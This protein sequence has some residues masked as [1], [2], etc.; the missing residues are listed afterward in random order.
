MTHTNRPLVILKVSTLVASLYPKLTQIKQ[1]K[2]N[3]IY[4]KLIL[5]ANVINILKYDDHDDY[6]AHCYSLLLMAMLIVQALH[7]QATSR[8]PKTKC[9]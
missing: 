7:L 3:N 5:V 2:R 1:I 6:S 4:L 9:L 8:K